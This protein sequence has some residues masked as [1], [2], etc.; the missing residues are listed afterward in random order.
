MHGVAADFYMSLYNVIFTVLPPL[1][2]GMFD[3]DVDRD[4][5]RL[6]PGALL[7]IS[8][9]YSFKLSSHASFRHEQ[10]NARVLSCKF[11]AAW[12]HA[13]GCTRQAQRICTSGRWRWQVGWSMPFS[14]RQSC[15]SWSCLP[16]SPSM[17]TAALAPPSLTGRCVDFQ[18]NYVICWRL[19]PR[20]IS[21][22]M[23]CNA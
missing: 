14:R 7:P 1:I 18:C 2:I 13:Q 19:L 23:E 5:S 9:A 12:L 20:K 11:M 21:F 17:P 4:M 3:Q 15:L 22:V 6:Y 16:H 10:L 8:I